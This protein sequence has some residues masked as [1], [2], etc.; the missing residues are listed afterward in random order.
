MNLQT[1]TQW[2]DS[3]SEP[4]RSSDRRLSA[5][6]VPTFSDRECHVVSVMDPS[7]RI[8]GFLDRSRYFFLEVAPQLYSGGWV[9]PVPGPLLHR[10]SGSAGNRTPRSGT[11]FAFHKMQGIYWESTISPWT[12][13]LKLKLHGLSPR[14]NYTDRVT[15]ACRRSGCQL[16][17][18]KGATWSA[19]RIPTAV[20][21]IF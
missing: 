7:G 4:Y 1:Q 12:R 6:L 14:A 2:Q 8:F 20:Y 13:S 21:S 18:T 16:L 15:A 17:R 19:W 11:F 3:A 9:D 10:K 5:K